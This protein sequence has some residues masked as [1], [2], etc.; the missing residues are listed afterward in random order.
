[1]RDR[2]K[3]TLVVQYEI[4]VEVDERVNEE[5]LRHAAH[6]SFHYDSDGR[7]PFS[8][9]QIYRGIRETSECFASVA[10][11]ALASR[12]C[13]KYPSNLAPYQLEKL[14]PEPAPMWH[15]K[16]PRL[17]IDGKPVTED[18]EPVAEEA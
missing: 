5:D 13:H 16:G 7:N 1:M 11:S 2:R 17:T 8:V 12:I 9:E 14:L 4:E 3:F 15:I 18:D 10:T 6:M